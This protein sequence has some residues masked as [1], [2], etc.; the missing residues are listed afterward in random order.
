VNLVSLKYGLDLS[1]SAGRLMA[2]VLASVAAYETEVRGERTRAGQEVAR[3]TGKHLGRPLG[4][5]APL[6][7]TQEQDPLV[8]RRKAEGEKIASIARNRTISSHDLSN[9][10]KPRQGP[11]V[12]ADVDPIV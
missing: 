10:S 12:R 7:V 11:D 1:S 6:E 9:S 5:R 8:R 3:A 2:N 4:I